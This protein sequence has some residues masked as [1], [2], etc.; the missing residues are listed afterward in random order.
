MYFDRMTPK[1]R[2]R[3]IA[4]LA[5]MQIAPRRIPQGFSAR[6]ERAKDLLY[7]QSQIRGR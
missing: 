3:D 7:P 4:E 6:D 1:A 5:A 2:L